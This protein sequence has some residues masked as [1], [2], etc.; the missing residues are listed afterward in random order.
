MTDGAEFLP[1]S[2][3]KRSRQGKPIH[4]FFF[5]SCSKKHVLCLI[6]AIK[7]YEKRTEATRREE[8]RLFVAIIQLYKAVTSSTITQWLKQ[9]LKASEIDAYLICSVSLSKAANMGITTNEILKTAD[10]SS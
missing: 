8:M 4:S 7:E 2:L 3:A 10:W 9:A 5:P 6:L 1:T